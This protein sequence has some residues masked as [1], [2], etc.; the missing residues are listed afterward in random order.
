M[1]GRPDGLEIF[2]PSEGAS[3]LGVAS[4]VLEVAIGSIWVVR[5]SAEST[6]VDDTREL[7]GDVP[8]ESGIVASIV[9]IEVLIVRLSCADLVSTELDV[10]AIS[11]SGTEVALEIHERL[12]TPFDWGLEKTFVGWPI[13]TK[14][15]AVV[16][17]IAEYPP[18]EIEPE[19]MVEL[20]VPTTVDGDTR[21]VVVSL[22]LTSLVGECTTTGDVLEVL[23]E[24]S[25]CEIGFAV[26]VWVCVLARLVTEIKLPLEAR[27][28][29]GELDKE[30]SV[31]YVDIPGVGTDCEGSISAT[32][33]TAELTICDVPDVTKK[34]EAELPSCDRSEASEVLTMK[35]KDAEGADG[36]DVI[37]VKPDGCDKPNIPETSEIRPALIV[38]TG[39][40]LDIVSW[41]EPAELGDCTPVAPAPITRVGDTWTGFSDWG[42]DEIKVSVGDLF[43]ELRETGSW[44]RIAEASMVDED[45]NGG[46]VVAWDAENV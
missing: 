25:G 41:L 19:E 2:S 11:N 36:S 43:D 3:K 7:T 40:E 12:T 39:L 46:E 37:T 15:S 14:V 38:V 1:V 20:C 45:P 6:S 28:S 9:G 30:R 18:L 31:E 17:A 33:L 23:M 35:L 32:V 16:L 13:D 34:L 4:D 5:F 26:D 10:S 8:V 21:L 44:P 22:K 29:V 24:P 42:A 27:I